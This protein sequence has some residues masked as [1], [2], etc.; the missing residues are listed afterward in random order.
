MKFNVR[1]RQ[2]KDFNN[3][4]VNDFE[5]LKNEITQEFKLKVKNNNEQGEVSVIKSSR[6]KT[7]KIPNNDNHLSTEE[8]KKTLQP[9]TANNSLV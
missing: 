1:L 4:A 9:P 5:N 7:A 3:R 6:G 8:G 2:D